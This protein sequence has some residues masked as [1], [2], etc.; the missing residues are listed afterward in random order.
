MR[1]R[2]TR[3]K[4]RPERLALAA[5]GAFDVMVKPI[6]A[7]CNLECAYC[8][9][10][11][12]RDLFDGGPRRMTLELLEEY[13]RQVLSARRT[14]EVTFTWQGGEPTLLGVE[15]FEHALRLQREY[16]EPGVCVSNRLQTNGTTL[17]DR[18]CRFL[19]RNRFLVGVSLDGPRPLHD[20]WRVDRFGKGSFDAVMAGVQ[21]LR[22]NQVEF[23]VLASVHAANVEHPLDVY[24]FLRD[25]AG[26]RVV[27][28]IP[29]VE[30]EGAHGR[31][32]ARSVTGARYGDFLIAIFDEW[33]RHDLGRVFV[34]TFEAALASWM[35]HSPGLCVFE[36]TCGRCL[37]LE[38]QGDV[39]CCDHYVDVEHL[40][41]NLRD[42]P[43]ERIAAS[44]GL[45]SFGRAKR[46]TLPGACRECRV[47][48]AC[49]GGCPKD[50]IARTSDG[51]PG[52]NHLC[53]G[54][55]AFFDHVDGPFRRI[56]RELRDARRPAGTTGRNEPCPCG[57]G[58]KLKRCHGRRAPFPETW[59]VPAEG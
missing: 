52:L 43:I 47:R 21:A 55:A 36:E 41:G 18:W 1:A 57:S 35:G 9:Y 19:R 40:L 5:P 30:P 14:P 50:R 56:A 44:P 25:V 58:R 23:N 59:T 48:F 29:I 15:F 42:T 12:K 32:S 27:Q 3:R 22:R 46:D 38:H 24:R 31:V 28:L 34:Q 7:T 45:R 2:G 16:A 39:F 13:T 11:P 17:D 49:N 20:V 4:A 10:L 6:G 37:V 51:E 54:Y 8:Y 53:A 26:A 33:L